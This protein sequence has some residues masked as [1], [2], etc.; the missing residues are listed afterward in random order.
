MNPKSDIF[1]GGGVVSSYGRPAFSL[2]WKSERFKAGFNETRAS[3]GRFAVGSI[4]F[5]LLRKRQEKLGPEALR[6]ENNR[7]GSQ[8][9]S[10][11]LTGGGPPSF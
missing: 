9:A 8:S 2:G 1:I 10:K 3:L 5:P 11:L 7:G 4:I 6:G